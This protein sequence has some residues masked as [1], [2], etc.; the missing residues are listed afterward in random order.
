[1]RLRLALAGIA[2]GTTLLAGCTG[3]D[4]SADP[5]PDETSSSSEPAEETT[6]PDVDAPELPEAATEQSEAGAEAFVRYYIDALNH[7]QATGDSGLLAQLSGEECL[8]CLGFVEAVDEVYA[9]SGSV[10]GGTYAIER[11]RPLPLDY[12]ADW[13]G[14]VEMTTAPQTIRL[15]DG[16]VEEYEGGP[17]RIGAYPSWAGDSWEMTWLALPTES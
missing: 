9:G 2:A 14:Y 1:M 8:G 16:T 15:D 6:E 5:S 13:G 7:A 3:D 17:Y 10:D 4:A 11:I 12:G